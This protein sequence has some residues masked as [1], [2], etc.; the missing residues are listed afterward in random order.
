MNP[1][2]SHV[3]LPWQQLHLTYRQSLFN[4]RKYPYLPHKFLRP[5]P[6]LP[7]LE[8]PIGG[9]MDIFWNCTFQLKWKHWKYI[10]D[11][12]FIFHNVVNNINSGKTKNLQSWMSFPQTCASLFNHKVMKK[13]CISHQP[14]SFGNILSENWHLASQWDL[15]YSSGVLY[16]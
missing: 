3:L 15:N 4:S 11:I 8:I 12:I 9:S 5:P 6:P 7:T 16:D 14:S 13:D 10:L 1:L 2:Q